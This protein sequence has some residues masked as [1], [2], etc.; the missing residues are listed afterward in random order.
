M[1]SLFKK[2]Y[3]LFSPNNLEKIIELFLI[4][5]SARLG[6]SSKLILIIFE[7]LISNS[8]MHDVSQYK[9]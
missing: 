3:T 4:D 7:K 1:F 5:K 6:L 8:P 2:Q 9:F